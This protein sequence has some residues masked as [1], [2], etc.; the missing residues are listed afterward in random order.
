MTRY[1]YKLQRWVEGPEA[2]TLARVQDLQDAAYREW[3]AGTITKAEFDARFD[4]GS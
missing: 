1:D 2:E 4:A 3:R